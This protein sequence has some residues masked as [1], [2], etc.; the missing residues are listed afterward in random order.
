MK[1]KKM[2]FYS[3]FSSILRPAQLERIESRWLQSQGITS[4]DLTNLS[5]IEL[6]AQRA[7]YQLL[8]YPCKQLSE[9]ENLVLKNFLREKRQPYVVLKIAKKHKRK[10]F[11]AKR[12]IR[13]LMNGLKEVGVS[14]KGIEGINRR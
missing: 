3:D 2:D 10:T 1:Q 5:T 14:R 12:K 8:Q 6:F 4:A 9:E 7:V 11:M 13:A